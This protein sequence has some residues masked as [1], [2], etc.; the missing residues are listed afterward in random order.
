M[1]YDGVHTLGVLDMLSLPPSCSVTLRSLSRSHAKVEAASILLPLKNPQRL[2]GVRRAK[3]SI[4]SEMFS[5][6]IRG[7]LELINNKGARVSLER[8]QSFV[9]GVTD[10]TLNMAHLDCLKDL[11]AQS[12]EILCMEGYKSWDGDALTVDSVKKALNSLGNI[13]ILILSHASMEPFFLVLEANAAQGLLQVQTLIIH[14]TTWT[15]LFGTDIL[16]TLLPVAR[17]RKAAGNPFKSV[18]VFLQLV[19]TPGHREVEEELGELRGCIE[20]FELVTGDD[21]L[22]WDV[23]KYFLDELEHLWN[24]RN[25]QWDLSDD[26]Y[27]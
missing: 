26:M 8:E 11:N 6:T 24:N 5:Y 12:A 16:Q 9:P 3:L 10:D 15:D 19:P 20:K 21:V 22:D 23:D 14:C 2:A 13:T 1:L 18:S 27:L 4:T 25:V 17:R 7:V